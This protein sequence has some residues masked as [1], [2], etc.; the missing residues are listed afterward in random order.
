MRKL[1][2]VEREFGTVVIMDGIEYYNNEYLVAMFRGIG[3]PS[4]YPFETAKKRQEKAEGKPEGYVNPSA[5]KLSDA[6]VRRVRAN[7]E[8]LSINKWAVHFKVSSPV[9][10]NIVNGKSYK[11]VK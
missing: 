9:I 6:D 5:R 1:E 4:R 2:I 3:K 10:S 7:V 11:D 8:G